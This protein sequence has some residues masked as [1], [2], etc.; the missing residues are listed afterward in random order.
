MKP[1]IHLYTLLLAFLASLPASPATA[2]DSSRED[3][4]AFIDEMQARHGFEREWLLQT[5][6]GATTQQRILDLISKPAERVRPWH[7]Y[8]D[9]FLTEQ[10]IAEGL[11]FWVAHRELLAGVAER[12]GV[13]PHVIVGIIGVETY[14]GRITGSFRVLDALAT[15]AFDYPPRSGYFRA[16]LEQ[17]LLLSREEP[18]DLG[19][20]QGSYAGAMGRPQFMPRSYR[21]FAVDG[22]GDARRDLWG[23]WADVVASIANYLV[24]HGWR[25]GEPVVAEA[26]L[27]YPDAD[28]LRAGSI[29]TDET[30]DS[31][32]DKGLA[33]ATPLPG[34][35]PAV[36]IAVDG[37]T[38]RE[39]RAGF[40]NFAAITKYNRSVMYALA[41]ND[42]GLAIAARL[43]E[44]DGA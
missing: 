32:R 41:V 33:F 39:L 2:L 40:A 28:S 44:G 4:R 10:R 25:P 21:V 13:A 17:F 26:R 43:P 23:S 11:G 38:G 22:D 36:F 18:V 35:A 8:R 27:W 5:L 34:A 42:L 29:E 6:G 24:E 14:Y 3:V 1:T 20:V 37:A 16:E 9:H 12:T 7:E 19:S 31:L 15:L 30:V